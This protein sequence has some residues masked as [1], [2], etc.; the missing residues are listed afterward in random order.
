MK[1]YTY[2]IS[3]IIV[4]IAA[5]YLVYCLLSH[6]KIT[7]FTISGMLSNASHWARDWHVLAV[8]FLPIYI[9][10]MVFGTALMSVYLVSYIK[11]WIARR[12]KS[13]FKP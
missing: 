2:H 6:D 9:A 13:R 5:I 4:I 3:G 8:G 1:K 10:L 12:R 11:R 7:P